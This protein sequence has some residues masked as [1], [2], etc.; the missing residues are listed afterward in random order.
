MTRQNKTFFGVAR[1]VTI[2]QVEMINWL[3]RD[4]LA[5]FDYLERREDIVGRALLEQTRLLLG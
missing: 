1:K 3:T 5:R 4:V 2:M